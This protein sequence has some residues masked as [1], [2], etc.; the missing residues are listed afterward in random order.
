MEMDST[1]T[2]KKFEQIKQQALASIDQAGRIHT[3]TKVNRERPGGA[4]K[5]PPAKFDAV[6]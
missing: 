3:N 2:I 4:F 1:P 6:P 5:L